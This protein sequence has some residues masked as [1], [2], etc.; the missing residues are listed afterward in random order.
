MKNNYEIR[1]D[2]VIIFMDSKINGKMETLISTTKLARVLEYPNTWYP[3]YSKKTDSFYAHGNVTVSRGKRTT[4]SLS[5][6]LFGN[7]KGKIVDHKNH[8]TL[9]NTDENL[10]KVTNAEN[11]QNRKGAATNSAS[12]VRGVNWHKLSQKWSVELRINGKKVHIGLFDDIREAEQAA[13]R[14][15]LER[16]PYAN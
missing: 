11:M 9:N 14:S 1:G 2:V 5:R 10:R 15:R 16:M 7:P 8:D 12:G 4:V 3:M 13:K 6:W